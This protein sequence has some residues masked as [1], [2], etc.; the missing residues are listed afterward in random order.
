M[1]IVVYFNTMGEYDMKKT[2]KFGGSSVANANQIKKLTNIV[3]NDK[4][5]RAIVVSAPGKRF[6]EDIKVTDLLINLYKDYIQASPSYISSLDQII[7]RYEDIARD[8]GLD[9]S[10]IDS[11][12]EILIGFLEDIDDDFYLENAIKS[13]GEDFNA[14]LIAAHLKNQSLD[15][16]YI[17][18][19]DLGIRLEYSLN[20]SKF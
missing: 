13:A 20:D 10:L 14:R 1:Q 4:D 16:K 2:A 19:K 18:P 17:S 5:I 11:F 3:K 15:A 12:R 7:L 9:L 6:K 8:L